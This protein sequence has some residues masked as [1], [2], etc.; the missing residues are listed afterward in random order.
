M[1]AR[2]L[3]NRPSRPRP[4]MLPYYLAGQPALFP[5]SGT[6]PLLIIDPRVRLSRR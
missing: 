1:P 2:I 3:T 6:G 4:G 5:L